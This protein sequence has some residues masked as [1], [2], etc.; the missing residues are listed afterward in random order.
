MSTIDLFE[1][2]EAKD[3][4]AIILDA[5][6]DYTENPSEKDFLLLAFGLTHLR[7]WIS[8]STASEICSKNRMGIPL[9]PGEKFFESIYHIEAFKIVQKLCNR[10]KHFL[11]TDFSPTTAKITGRPV[12]IARLG[13]RE[14]QE[15]F[16]IN[17]KD[18]R[19][20][21]LELIQKYNSWFSSNQ[22]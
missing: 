21:F 8:E 19:D 1:I 2:N 13:D 11:S 9:T 6:S 20:Y 14:N 15:Q 3:L 10:G 17:K 16:L 5:Y 12:G 4:Y 7:E 22:Y 18:S